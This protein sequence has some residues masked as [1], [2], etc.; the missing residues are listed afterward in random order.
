MPPLESVPQGRVEICSFADLWALIRVGMMSAFES[1]YSSRAS[2]G[3]PRSGLR[4]Q[5]PRRRGDRRASDPHGRR[6]PRRARRLS[7]RRPAQ[8]PSAMPQFVA[9][10]PISRTQSHEPLHRLSSSR[11]RPCSA[12]TGGATPSC[13]ARRAREPMIRTG[14]FSLTRCSARRAREPIVPLA[15]RLAGGRLSSSRAQVHRS[16]SAPARPRPRARVGCRCDR[17]AATR[18]GIPGRSCPPGTR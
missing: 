5:P 6:H 9:C 7:W 3:G 15:L 4:L 2:V 14:N 17:A 13:S 8:S 10:E 11:A 12:A 16:G 1:I 18:R